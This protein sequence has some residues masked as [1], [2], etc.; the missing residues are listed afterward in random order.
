MI[1]RSSNRAASTVVV[2]LGAAKIDR[3]AHHVGMRRF[4]LDRAIWGRSLI[5]AREESRFFLHIDARLP[6]RHRAWGMELLRTVVPKQRWGIG[7]VIPA[8]WT[9][10]FK[11]G[12]GSGIGLVDH[13]VALLA[14]GQE[15]VSVAVLTVTNGTHKTGKATLRGV[16]A[17]LLRGLAESPPA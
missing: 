11:G 1:R 15:R 6:R 8:G 7:R 3:T 13:Q 4:H 17:R 12:W 14:R 16:F 9:A 2:R 5:T 10:Y